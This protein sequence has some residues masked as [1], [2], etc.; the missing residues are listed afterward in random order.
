MPL[1]K[2]YDTGWSDFVHFMTD[3]V[4]EMLAYYR[5]LALYPILGIVLVS[6]VITT[7]LCSSLINVMVW[8]LFRYVE[9]IIS[10]ADWTC[11]YFCGP[12]FHVLSTVTNL[13][14]GC[15]HTY[16]AGPQ[17]TGYGYG[18]YNRKKRRSSGAGLWRY[19][20]QKRTHTICR[21]TTV[22]DER[23]AAGDDTTMNVTRNV[24]TVMHRWTRKLNYV[25]DRF[26]KPSQR[27][28]INGTVMNREKLRPWRKHLILNILLGITRTFG[29]D[30]Q[31]Y[32][33]TF[34]RSIPKMIYHTL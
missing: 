27:Q 29:E 19:T 8:I 18:P 23:E 13:V 28:S 15:L 22:E 31:R 9:S 5:S 33:L 26:G 6:G 4:T 32:L 7:W 20:W 24:L 21:K 1:I 17:T 3:V 14:D 12:I 11:N 30:R 16:V 34:R 2:P 10:M 25:L